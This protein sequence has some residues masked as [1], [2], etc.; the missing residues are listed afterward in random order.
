MSV[1]SACAAVTVGVAV[2]VTVP[3][4]VANRQPDAGAA[5]TSRQAPASPFVYPPD[6]LAGSIEGFT[7]GALTVTGTVHVTP[8]YQVAQIIDASRPAKATDAAGSTYGYTSARGVVTVYR[9][10]VFDPRAFQTGEAVSVNGRPGRYAGAVPLMNG[11]QPG[12]ALAWQYADGAWAVASTRAKDPL[13]RQQLV[14]VA[15]GLRSGPP[16]TPAVGF[17]LGYV[18]AGFKL[19][20]AGT[21]DWMLATSLPGQSYV[22]LV[23]GTAVYA[24]LTGPLATPVAN[25]KQLPTLE[26]TLFPSWYA[27]YSAPTG[28]PKNASFCQISSLC[29]RSTGDGRWQLE[30]NGGLATTDQELIRMLDSITFADPARP[31]S[32]YPITTALPAN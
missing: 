7:A 13:S 20:G 11:L 8:G 29:Y 5:A 16:R 26:L 23:K 25:G 12:P 3:Q 32:W 19:A 15:A 2:A 21:A 14:D 27:K 4:A 18:P 10:G 24:G 17:K 1:I 28:T 6:Q 30:V 31:S 22:R 9:A